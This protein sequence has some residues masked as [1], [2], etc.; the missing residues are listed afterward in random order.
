MYTYAGPVLMKYAENTFVM[1][2]S[3]LN[4]KAPTLI[5]YTFDW[6]YITKATNIYRNAGFTWE[7]GAFAI[8]LNIALIFKLFLDKSNKSLANKYN[9]VYIISIISTFSTTGY[10]VLFIILLAYLLHYKKKIFLKWSLLLIA[11]PLSYQIYY[12]APFLQDKIDTQYKESVN[13]KSHNRFSS[14]ILDI[15]D[16]MK[17]PLLGWSRD[18]EILFGE[19]VTYKAHRPNGITNLL[20]CYGFIYF[21]FLFTLL[22]FSFYKLGKTSTIKSAPL[23]SMFFITVLLLSAFSQLVFDKPFFRSM[24]FWGDFMFL[25]SIPKGKFQQLRHKYKSHFRIIRSQ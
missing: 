24:V 1:S 6:G 7:A 17:R 19:E 12:S 21:I 4:Y 25:T 3:K 13:G 15:N 22:Y 8:Y 10:I 23:F 9:I 2:I 20:R 5:F 14:A 16:V 11:I 18:T